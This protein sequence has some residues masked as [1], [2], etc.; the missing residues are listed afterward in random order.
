ML[1]FLY[2]SSTYS[3]EL[4]QI[5]S[6]GETALPQSKQPV[7]NSDEIF[8]FVI[9]ADRTGGHRPGVFAQ[10]VEKINLMQPEFVMSV[11][12]LIEG[13]TDE[14]REIEAQWNE[15]DRIVGKADMRFY[16]LAGNHDYSN[17]T[18]GDIWKKRLGPDFYHFLY[19][20][21][22]FLCLNSEDGYRGAGKPYISD[23]QFTYFQQVLEQ[24]PKVRWTFVFMH[25]P[26]WI[27]EDTGLWPKLEELLR[28]R[29]HTI[30]AGH[31]HA[32]THFNRNESDYIILGTTGGVSKMRGKSHG[33]VDH[34]TWVTLNERGPVISNLMLEGIEAMDFA[35]EKSVEIFSRI[36]QEPPVYVKPYFSDHSLNLDTVELVIR[37]PFAY[38]MQLQ[39]K[40]Y[41]NPHMVPSLTQWDELVP[42]ESEKTVKIP[43]SLIQ[44]N[45][46]SYLKPLEFHLK[47]RFL[48]METQ[49]A[50]WQQVV[51]FL[52]QPYHSIQSNSKP[53]FLDGDM[54]EW[55]A[56]PFHIESMNKQSKASF[57]FN[58]VEEDSFLFIGI[59]VIDSDVFLEG[60]GLGFTDSEGIMISLDANSQDISALNTGELSTLMQG[61]WMVIGINPLEKKG[62]IS[63]QKRLQARGIDGYYALSKKGYSAEIK[64]NKSLIEQIQ[65]ENWK[66]VRLNIRVNDLKGEG[67]LYPLSWQKDWWEKGLP[68]TG[69]FKRK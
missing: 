68:G 34:L 63:Y 32:Y 49:A 56:F 9:V 6:R 58:M 15:F 64:I 3:Q 51:P 43:I 67:Q 1:V 25:Q 54:S 11:G 27:H 48:N 66:T 57:S 40:A 2:L 60:K 22:L 69:M 30:F 45:K 7:L 61:K 13:Y 38:T 14:T 52:P 47:G 5:D 50:E 62:A 44:E 26:L 46:I 10:A 19:K 33:E 20:D 8:Q 31:V 17:Q 23:E 36:S 53:V 59:K 37:N 28:K 21:A 29:K 24:N 12:D 42:P 65:G 18:M 4:P 35:T 55:D 39:L 16:Y 41:A